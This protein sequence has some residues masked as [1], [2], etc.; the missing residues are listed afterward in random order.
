[1]KTHQR[2][3]GG[4]KSKFNKKILDVDHSVCYGGHIPL[5]FLN[6]GK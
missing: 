1:M 5:A 4:L 2:E 6:S 3:L